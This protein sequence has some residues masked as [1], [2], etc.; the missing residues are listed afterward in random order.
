[1]NPGLRQREVYLHTDEEQPENNETEL[2]VILH[3]WNGLL[4]AG[5]EHVLGAGARDEVMAGSE[6]ITASTS[7]DERARWTCAAM[8]RLDQLA[9]DYQRFDI[10]SR[11][12]HV[13]PQ[14]RIV[15]LRA[16]YQQNQD[17]DQ[18]LK[19][20]GEDV[21]WYEEPVRKGNVLYATKAPF[22]PQGFEKA[23]TRAEKRK[24]YCHCSIIKNHLDE[25]NPTFCHCGAGWYRQLWEGIL[26]KPVR[27]EML[28]SLPL[29]DDVCQF[30]IHLPI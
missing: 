1:L 5:L 29:G 9:G 14:E 19:V 6:Q 20:M 21:Y 11:C 24:H 23:E 13:F 15:K 17:V 25:M 12:A 18:V 27:V 3:D 26:E 16:V 4:A 8:D 2:H 30:A 10:V 28:K 7:G 22:D